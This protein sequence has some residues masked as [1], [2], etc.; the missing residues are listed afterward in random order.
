MNDMNNYFAVKLLTEQIA[1]TI[2]VDMNNA[3]DLV[4]KIS[5]SLLEQNKKENRL[6]EK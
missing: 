4:E 1:A 6:D 5:E 2:R 3:D